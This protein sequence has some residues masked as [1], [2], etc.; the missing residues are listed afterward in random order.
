M[1]EGLKTLTKPDPTNAGRGD[2]V[3]PVEHRLFERK[4][5]DRLSDL[6]RRP[7]PQIQLPA[8]LLDQGFD[9]TLHDRLLAPVERVAGIAHDLAGLRHVVELLA[10]RSRPT[11][12]FITV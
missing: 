5:D 1:L 4:A 3:P 12:C 10:S 7:I 6:R 11:L 9:T 2:V 8:R